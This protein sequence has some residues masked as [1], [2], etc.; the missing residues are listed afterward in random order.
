MKIVNQFLDSTKQANVSQPDSD[1]GVS[2]PELDT[3]VPGAELIDLPR[4][5][6]ITVDS[7][8]YREVMER[9]RSTRKYS[10]Q[11]LSIEQLSWLI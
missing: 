9:R 10:E 5:D 3:Q 6:T 7:T 8:P 2:A 4:P 11:P 1:K